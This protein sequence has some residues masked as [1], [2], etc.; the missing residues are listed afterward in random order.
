MKLL[1]WRCVKAYNLAD[2]EEAIS[3]M[4]DANPVAVDAFKKCGPY[5][6][7]RSFVKLE[8]K[9]DVILTNMVET[10]NNYIMNARSH[11]LIYMLEEIRAMLMKRM[12]NNKRKRH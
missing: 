1:F 4:E 6:F 8:G 10:F 2:F 12:A 7:C 11:H 9:C 5:L 3:E